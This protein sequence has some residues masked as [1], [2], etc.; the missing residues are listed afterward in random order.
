MFGI[1]MILEPGNVGL[2]YAFTLFNAFLGVFVGISPMSRCAA[3]P[4]N[5]L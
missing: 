2:Q 1:L 3:P 5:P 4:T